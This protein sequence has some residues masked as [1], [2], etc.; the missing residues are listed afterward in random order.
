M[1]SAFAIR[2]PALV[3]LLIIL[4]GPALAKHPGEFSCYKQ[5]C[6]RVAT[7][8]QLTSVRGKP[9]KAI[10]THY[11]IPERDPFNAAGLTS[12]GEAFDPKSTSRIS[13]TNLP[14]GTVVAL[15]SPK[16][17]IAAKA[18]VNNTGPFWGDRV[19]DAPVALARKMGFHKVGVAELRVAVLEVPDNEAIKYRK[20]R[21]YKFDGGII[22]RFKT[23]DAI[24]RHVGIA[25]PADA[26]VQQVSALDFGRKTLPVP[27]PAL[28]V[29]QVASWA[30]RQAV[31]HRST[32]KIVVV[33]RAWKAGV[34]GVKLEG[35]N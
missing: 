5:T 15:W 6:W 16:T 20:N 31:V 17:G 13:S 28:P 11:D 24:L 10:A 8:D 4:T 22:G 14:N 26:K 27:H 21:D 35:G 34:F 9:F 29:A 18:I 33:S 32:P 1:T 3:A 7:L 19:V 23:F 2:V 12:S 25:E 30:K